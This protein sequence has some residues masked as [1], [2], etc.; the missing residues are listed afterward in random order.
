MFITFEGGE[1]AGKTT[2]LKILADTLTDW[3]Y[4][5]ITTREPGGTTLGQQLRALLLDPQ[6]E[7][8][9]LAELLLF[10]ADRAQHVAQVIQPALAQG[11]IVLCDRYIDSTLAYQGW[12]RGLAQTDL[13]LLNRLESVGLLPDLTLWLDLPPLVGRQRAQ[14]APDR[15]EADSLAFHERVRAGFT[16]L[17][18]QEPQRIQ[19]LDA[20]L[21][22]AEVSILIRQILARH[23]HPNQNL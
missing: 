6:T 20:E 7:I 3:G 13:Q 16:H 4:K 22:I 21:S 11:A 23:L 9:P 5:V 17:H 10:A 12:G 8:F 14:A 1:G 18:Q 2:Q 15:M 19:R